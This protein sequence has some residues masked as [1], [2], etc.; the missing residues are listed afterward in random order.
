M[1]PILFAW[2]WGGHGQ[3]T[4]AAIAYAVARLYPS[5]CSFVM[6]RLNQFAALQGTNRKTQE[7]I[8]SI[9]KGVENH[10]PTTMQANLIRLFD[11]M[12]G[13]V[14][15][16]D[17]HIGNIPVVGQYLESDAQVR[18]FMRS[19]ETTTQREAYLKS[20]KHIWDNLCLAWRHMR[21][22]IFHQKHWYDFLYNSSFSDFDDGIENLA[23]ALHTIED[24]Y[25]PGHVKR[26][27]SSG[28][29]E[30]I[31]YWDKENKTA[32]KDWPGHEALDEPTTAQSRPFFEMCRTDAADLIHCVL[33]NLDQDEGT[34]LQDLTERFNKHFTAMNL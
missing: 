16:E 32:S 28:V 2:S 33:A 6:Q 30:E 22:G 18:H 14:Q 9:V 13:M 11:D 5:G 15:R 24:S 10:S 3:I 29:I 25:A 4:C 8:E 34:F 7:Q 21:K 23:A 19:T 31:H 17:I 26:N 1:L 12:P 20:R 27:I